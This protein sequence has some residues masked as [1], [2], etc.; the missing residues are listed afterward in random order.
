MR[1]PSLPVLWAILYA[2]V[3]TTPFNPLLKNAGAVIP[4][5]A[6]VT[7]AH[8]VLLYRQTEKDLVRDSAHRGPERNAES[9]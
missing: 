8:C 2:I 3:L 6:A 7:V 9:L 5:I 1:S 4:Y